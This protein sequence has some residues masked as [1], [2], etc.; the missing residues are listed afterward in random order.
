[1]KSILTLEKEISEVY[2]KIPKVIEL[3]YNE[4]NN[5]AIGDKEITRSILYR[6]HTFYHYQDKLNTF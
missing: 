3:A 1:M 2:Q 5:Q 4:I 6:L